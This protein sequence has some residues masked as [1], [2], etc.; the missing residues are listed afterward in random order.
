MQNRAIVS[1]NI[2]ASCRAEIRLRPIPVYFGHKTAYRTAFPVRNILKRL[3]YSKFQ[4]ETRPSVCLT[5]AERSRFH[6]D[7]PKVHNAIFSCNRLLS[8]ILACRLVPFAPECRRRLRFANQQL[9]DYVQEALMLISPP[10]ANANG[11]ELLGQDAS[12]SFRK[13]VVLAGNGTQASNTRL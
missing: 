8:K 5:T 13:I 11:T 4:P 3:P 1:H 10:A 9:S 2:P 12:E 7:I 6:R